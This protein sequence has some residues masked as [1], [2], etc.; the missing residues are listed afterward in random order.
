MR[1][2]A[3]ISASLMKHK[4]RSLTF[5]L[6]IGAFASAL[7]LLVGSAGAATSEVHAD[8]PIGT[9]TFV[10][11][12]WRDGTTERVEVDGPL[13]QSLLEATV[14]A[15][16]KAENR[17][18]DGQNGQGSPQVHARGPS[19]TR[20]PLDTDDY[21]AS[22]CGWTLWFPFKQDSTT[23]A[24]STTIQCSHDVTDLYISLYLYKGGGWN[25][26]GFD[27]EAGTWIGGAYAT[28]ACANGNWQY[29]AALVYSWTSENGSYY[30]PVH[31]AGPSWFT[32]WV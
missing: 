17:Q 12:R 31:Y 28:G 11:I 32:C 3:L 22:Y 5:T 24:T 8:Q 9:P 25:L 18:Q 6:V 21:G 1:Q 30:P 26:I 19:Q 7:I 14:A 27:S 29:N 20:R 4:T 16:A 10:D 2:L 23:V 13:S 15:R